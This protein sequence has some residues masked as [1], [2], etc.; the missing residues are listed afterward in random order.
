MPFNKIILE[1]LIYFIGI[2][3]KNVESFPS[4]LFAVVIVI[5]PPSAILNSP[6]VI[7]FLLVKVTN[8]FFVYHGFLVEHVFLAQDNILCPF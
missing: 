7:Y 1:F 5:F 8:A 4:P 6:S 3:P 2:I